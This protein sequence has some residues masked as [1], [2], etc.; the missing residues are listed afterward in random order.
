MNYITLPL[1]LKMISSVLI[2]HLQ[3]Q[4]PADRKYIVTE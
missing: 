3:L 2:I 1:Q 4:S